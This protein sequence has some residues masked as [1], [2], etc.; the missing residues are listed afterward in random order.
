MIGRAH[1]NC[2]HYEECLAAYDKA[3]MLASGDKEE[4]GNIQL[5]RG[6]ILKILGRY[7][8]GISAH[9]WEFGDGTGSN[10]AEPT[11]VFANEGHFDVTLTVTAGSGQH[12]STRE[13]YIFLG[14][15]ANGF[16]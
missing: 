14:L 13:R 15:F 7:D 12:T 1:G 2:G 8:D 11:H 16:E 5:V 9:A 3:L 10:V 4:T 6:H